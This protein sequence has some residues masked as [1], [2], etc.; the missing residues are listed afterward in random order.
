MI[1]NFLLFFSKV[2]F[3]IIC[4]V[5]KIY[6]Y[7]KSKKNLFYFFLYKKIHFFIVTYFKWKMNE[8]RKLFLCFYID[9]LLFDCLFVYLQW[10]AT[11]TGK[12]KY[13]PKAMPCSHF[14]YLKIKMKIKFNIFLLFILA[15]LLKKMLFFYTSWCNLKM[16][17]TDNKQWFFL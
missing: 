17:A 8:K 7:F 5:N 2:D 4:S 14:I 6:I 3:S 1:Q 13:R 10:C 9:F 16:K 12:I 11:E 15:I